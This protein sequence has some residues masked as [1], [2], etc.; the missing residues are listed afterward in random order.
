MKRWALPLLTLAIA[1]I[2]DWEFFYGNFAR[3][4]VLGE[5]P[6]IAALTRTPFLFEGRQLDAAA[7]EMAVPSLFD[8]PMQE[9]FRKAEVVTEGKQK[10]VF[11]RGTIFIF[12]EVKK[13]EWRFTEIGA[14]D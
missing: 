8:A 5:A 2:G 11:C 14:D 12:E 9:C 13:G 7:F 10:M 4:V 1:P 3:A 6:K